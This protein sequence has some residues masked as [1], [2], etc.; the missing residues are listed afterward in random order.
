MKPLLVVDDNQD[1]RDILCRRLKRAGYEVSSASDGLEALGIIDSEDIDM[2]LLDS[3]MPGMSGIELLRLLRATRSPEQL[4]VIMVTA[5]SGSDKIVEALNHGANDYITKPVD[6][7]VALAR[8]QSQLA[9]KRAE[10]ALRVSEERFSL[11]ARGAN[12]GLWDWDLRQGRVY[13]SQR[14][15][16]MLG[17]RSVQVSDSPEEWRSRVHPADREGFEAEIDKVLRSG[18]DDLLVE[19]RLCRA[20]G[21]YCWMLVRGHVLR[22]PS[23]SPVR[24]AGSCT[25]V[26]DNKALDSLTGLPNRTLLTERIQRAMEAQRSGQARFALLFLDL[27]RFQVVNDSL[28]HAAGDRLLTAFAQ[29]LQ[30]VVRDGWAATRVFGPHAVARLGGDEFAVLLE[31]LCE[32]ENAEGVA[33]HI[34]ASMQAPFDVDGRELFTSVSIGIALGE[35]GQVT[36]D[37]VIRDADTALYRAKALG[38]GR[39]HMFS[40]DLR[41]AA[42]H[43]LEVENDLRRALENGELRAFYQPKISLSDNR[44]VG[45]EALARWQHPTR[46]LVMPDDFI[47]VAEETGL[48][49]P[50]GAWMLREACRQ[51]RQWQNE[52]PPE[53]LL[54]VSVN[55]SPRQFRDSELLPTLR[56]VLAE[57]GIPPRTLQLE[58]TESVLV[59]D[60][61]AAVEIL[62]EVTSLGVGVKLDDFGTGYS[63]LN[64]LT[65][66]PCESLKIDRSFVMRMCEDENSLQVIQTI[67]S[68]AQNLQMRVTAEGIETLEQALELRSLG[69]DYGQGYYFARPMPADAATDFARDPHSLPAVEQERIAG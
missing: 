18:A 48:I 66:L 44:L 12:D 55:L 4:P 51:L 21:T 30:A 15:K 14:W 39:A 41:A 20:D 9:R 62:R 53:A 29:R 46:G 25:D 23:G 33:A 43:R 64:Y 27:D 52:N 61:E 36:A 58:V 34:L 57:T 7:P 22:D 28:G 40:A 2:V 38:R 59:E 37:D 32:P 49:I 19:Q 63:S 67:L 26:T 31:D 1:N 47:P 65:R 13:Y 16:E 11:A 69:C 45:F 50:L 24:M 56:D 35:D 17:L 42:L 10:E 3:M 68:L 6:F 5:N 8:I 60:P 54:E